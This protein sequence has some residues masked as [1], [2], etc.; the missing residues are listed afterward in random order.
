MRAERGNSWL[1]GRLRFIG[2][3]VLVVG[4]VVAG[5]VMAAWRSQASQDREI[6]GNREEIGKVK[7]EVDGV[8]EKLELL[9]QMDGKLDRVL[10][11]LPP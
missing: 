9:G 6:S 7:V 3:I 4:T 8:K 5:V 2:A 10:E 11:R 1:E